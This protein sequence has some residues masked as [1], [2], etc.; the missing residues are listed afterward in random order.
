MPANVVVHEEKETIFR[1]NQAQPREMRW[2]W[3]GPDIAS[4]SLPISPRHMSPMAQ[5]SPTVPGS[6]HVRQPSGVMDTTT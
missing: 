5:V 6:R 2:F 3:Y 4:E 1:M